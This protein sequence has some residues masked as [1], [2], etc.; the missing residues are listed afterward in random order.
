MKNLCLPAIVSLLFLGLLA[1]CSRSSPPPAEVK[2]P[3]EK[4]PASV[5][6]AEWERKW[7]TILS[8]AKKEGI[9]SLYSLWRPE[10]RI[11][12]TK[13]FGDKYGIRLEY[14]P[15]GRGA[16]LFAKVQAEKRA[17][18]QVADVLG[19]GGGTLIGTMKPAEVLGQIEPLLILPEVIDP[20]SWNGDK[21]PFIDK[22]KSAIAM[23]AALQRDIVYNTELVKKGEITSLKDLLKPQYE[24][25]IS[26]NDPSVTGPGNAFMTLL[27]LGIWNVDEAKDY[28]RQ[29]VIK[30]KAVIQRD[31][32]LHLEEVVRGKY[33]IA[34]APLP[35]GLSEFLKSNVPIDVVISREGVYVT[36]AAGCIAIPTR[37]AHPNAAIVFINWL[38]SKEGQTVFA[39]SFGNPSL[40]KDVP[41]EGV[42]PALLPQPGE[43]LHLQSE[44]FILFQS[45][46]LGITKEII[47]EAMR[48][49]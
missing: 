25:K 48:S 31:N 29:L 3:L 2:A 32:R 5:Q 1:S 27:A 18:L 13:A 47:D 14:T 9:I 40:R 10:T 41:T 24:G 15:F 43:K 23:I 17:G 36:P 28:L 49:R 7:D 33:Y 45:K 12:L 39:K 4:T 42:L 44:E 11:A 22:D 16:E 21:F 37:P 6:K 26:M 46:M 38:L 20:K 34:L 35:D 30:Q 19:A 8:E